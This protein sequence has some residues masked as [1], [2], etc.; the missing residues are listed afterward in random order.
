M[1]APARCTTALER[2]YAPG[3]D[4]AARL[5]T[6]ELRAKFLVQGLFEPGKARLVLTDLDRLLIGGAIPHD[7]IELPPHAELGTRFFNERRETGIINLGDAG[8]VEVSGREYPLDPLDCLYIGMGEETIRLRRGPEGQAVY[9][10]ASAPAHKS[11]PTTRLAA[12]D[13]AATPIGDE[14]HA[15]RRAIH[16]YICPGGV[17]SCQLVMG[18]T[19]LEPNSVWN[20]MPA[21]THTRRSEIYLYTELGNGM[22]VHLMG[23][24]DETRHLIVRDREA[25]LSPPW[26]IHGGAGTNHYRFIWVMAGENQEFSDIDP[27]TLEQLF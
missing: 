27:L 10:L 21:H 25:V 11:Y 8:V 13:A 26:S 24:P 5:S 19:Q 4:E 6:A 18:F 14:F 2:R 15:A 1:T 3:P 9:Y 20:T 16:K 22:L 23:Q 12:R 17:A 7:P